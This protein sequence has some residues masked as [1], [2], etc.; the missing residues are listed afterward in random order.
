MS[1]HAAVDKKSMQLLGVGGY[2]VLSVLSVLQENEHVSIFYADE[3]RSYSQF[4]HE[5]LLRLH[6]SLTGRDFRG[7]YSDLISAVR[8]E[9]CARVPVP[10]TEQDLEA[11]VVARFG[12]EQFPQPARV[13]ARTTKL[14]K[15]EKKVEEI[16]RPSRGATARV[17]EICDTCSAQTKDRAALRAL[18]NAQAAA[19]GLNPSTVS[20][21]YGKWS[22]K[23]NP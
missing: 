11:R 7:S 23:N 5:E 20:V 18:V 14:A 21:Q 13:P 9:V 2:R 8:K 1:L 15:A 10:H 12:H 22:K 16:E 6:M 19:E 4:S 17:W 3:N